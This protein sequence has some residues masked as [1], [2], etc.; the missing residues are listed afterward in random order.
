MWLIHFQQRQCHLLPPP[1]SPSWSRSSHSSSS[2]SCSSR[3]CSSGSVCQR[4]RSRY[5]S[6]SLLV[7]TLFPGSQHDTLHFFIECCSKCCRIKL[8]VRGSYKGFI[9]SIVQYQ[10][11]LESVIPSDL[12]LL[13]QR[14]V[15]FCISSLDVCNSKGSSVEETVG[16]ITKTSMGGLCAL[17]HN[18]LV[19]FDFNVCMRYSV[20]VQCALQCECTVC[21][22]ASVYDSVGLSRPAAVCS[23]GSSA[24]NS[25]ATLASG[26]H[27]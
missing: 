10:I 23:Q 7:L 21:I 6:S 4:A 15:H 13:M 12:N 22:T 25:A 9:S 14:Q 5:D 19:S 20:C 11:R 1:W 2:R 16:V 17:W 24:P 26:G 3:S 27:L 8:T 18:A